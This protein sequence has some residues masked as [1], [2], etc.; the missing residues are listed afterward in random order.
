M[1]NITIP[2]ELKQLSTLFEKDLFV[3][4]GYVRDSLLNYVEHDCDLCGPATPNEV[5]KYL[6]NSPFIVHVESKK[7]MTLCIIGKESRYEYTTFRIDSYTSGHRPNDV[8][9]TNDIS[10]DAQRR[11]FTINAL[12]YDV[13]KEMLLD[14]LNLGLN[15][16]EKKTIRTTRA[17]ELVFAEDG[18]RLMRLARF[19]ASLDFTIDENTKKEATIHASLIKDISPERIKDELN[20]LLVSDIKYG[21]S[22]AIINGFDILR[23]IGVLE[24]ILPE[25][26]L[27]YGLEQ[28]PDYHKYDV[29]Y[30]ILHTVKEADVSVRLG[31]LMHDIAKPYCKLTFGYYRGHDYYGEKMCRKILTRLCYSKEI[32]DETATLVLTH[33]FNQ[34]RKTSINKQRLFVLKYNKYLDKI[35]L[36]KYA[37]WKGGGLAEGDVLESAEDLLKVRNEMLAE[38]VPFSVSEL[39]VNG[40][41]FVH[42]FTKIPPVERKN[43][44]NNLLHDCVI[45]I[46]RYRT[47]EQQ[48]AYLEREN[49][50]Y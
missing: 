22:D 44:L 40:Y 20:L 43:V 34:D 48:L 2:E 13:K 49:N 1:P 23:E 42:T 4:G 39:K 27:G 38:Q 36:I 50:K 25:L 46:N 47:R 8:V 18:L 26:T 6:E 41:D 12:Y 5:I 35:Y 19:A 24:I 37:D 30:H 31:A 15:D 9:C 11:D 7:M 14:P 29:Y 16:L 17:P 3:V 28:R 33:M 32:I 45:D 21:V 10:I